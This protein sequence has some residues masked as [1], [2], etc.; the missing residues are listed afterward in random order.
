MA[1]NVRMLLGKG[2]GRKT[3]ARLDID[4][5][6][7]GGV[8]SFQHASMPQEVSRR[9]GGKVGVWPFRLLPILI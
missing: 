5:V 2:C 6:R 1:Y 8:S 4:G 9:C 7:S 3:V